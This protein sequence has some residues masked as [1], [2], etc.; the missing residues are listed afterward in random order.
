MAE[1]EVNKTEILK[2]IKTQTGLELSL[3]EYF[4][5]VKKYNGRPYFNVILPNRVSEYTPQLRALE[6]L[7]AKSS[8]IHEIQPNGVS[9]VA[10][11]CK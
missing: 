5:E 6:R 8:M 10:I 2:H 11:V 1:Y 3:C 7:A 4:T 9:R